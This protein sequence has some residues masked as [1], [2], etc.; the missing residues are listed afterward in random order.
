MLCWDITLMLVTKVICS[1]LPQNNFMLIVLINKCG[2]CLCQL[3]LF[4]KNS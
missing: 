2:S 3:I 1:E 4:L